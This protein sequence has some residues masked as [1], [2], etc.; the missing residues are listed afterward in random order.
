MDYRIG[1]AKDFLEAEIAVFKK[2]VMGAGEVIER[3]FDDL[4][5]KNPILM[6]LPNTSNTEAIGALKIPNDSYKNDVFKRSN[7]I[8]QAKDFDYELGWI[9]SICQGKGNGRKVTEV[10]CSLETKI[11]ATARVENTT[12]RSILE[13]YGL[14]QTGSHF[15]SKNGD[16]KIVLYI[17]D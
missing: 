10:L 3:T 1:R 8:A 4:I 12:M 2:I 6:F 7:S 16:Y 15:D 13:L 9:V 11:Y 5:E 14:K 17:K